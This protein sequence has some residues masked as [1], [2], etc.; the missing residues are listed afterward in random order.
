MPKPVSKI[1]LQSGAVDLGVLTHVELGEVE[2]EDLDLADHVVQVTRGAEAAA[3]L[4][5]APARPRAG[6]RAAPQSRRR[7]WARSLDGRF[8]HTLAHEGQRPP[9]G[10]LG[11]QI[12]VSR[13]ARAGNCRLAELEYRCSRPGP[14][15]PLM[16][17][18]N[19]SRPAIVSTRPSRKRRHCS[20]QQLQGRDGRLGLHERVAVAI[21]A[22]PGAEVAGSV[23]R[24][25]PRPR[26]SGSRSERS[27]SR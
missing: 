23:G 11:V 10:L 15:G 21:T 4:A 1:S 6:R 16:R 2:A 19:E 20:L 22:D 27:R 12:A 24:S 8:A 25:D 13:C 3:I 14:A 18:E 5:P 17:S 9:V 26:G 7:R